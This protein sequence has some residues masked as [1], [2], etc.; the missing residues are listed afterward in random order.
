LHTSPVFLAEDAVSL[1][2]AAIVKSLRTHARDIFDIRMIVVDKSRPRRGRHG[3]TLAGG[4]E[5][6]RKDW[7]EV[8]QRFPTFNPEY[9]DSLTIYIENVPLPFRSTV[10]ISKLLSKLLPQDNSSSSLGNNLLIQSIV[11]PPHHQ[12]SPDAVPKC[13]GFALVTFSEPSATSHLLA[14]FPFH[15]RNASADDGNAQS[16]ELEARKAGFRTLS[17][18]RWDALQSE[19][20]EYR[21][22]LLRLIAESSSSAPASAAPLSTKPPSTAPAD[23]ARHTSTNQLPC[24]EIVNT[25]ATESPPRYPPGCVIFARHV[26]QDTNKTALRARFSSLLGGADDDTTALDYVDYTKGLDNCY[27]RLTTREHALS[28]LERF[29]GSATGEGIVLELLNGRREEMYWESLPD[30]VRALALQRAQAQKPQRGEGDVVQ[31]DDMGNGERK[32]RK[33]RR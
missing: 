32:R 14:Y 16:E 27:L 5:V 2:E 29:N 18:V 24:E 25:R 31:V 21:E 6:R 17:K 28:L 15:K 20:A 9:W 19:Y 7:A 30:K 23:K 4:Y 33:R 8:T 11:F 1:T 3:H 10:G 13:K 12:D 26:P 22:T